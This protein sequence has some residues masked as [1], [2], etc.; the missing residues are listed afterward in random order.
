MGFLDGLLEYFLLIILCILFSYVAIS[1]LERF[2]H[3]YFMH[4]K[5]PKFV[6]RIV[7]DII[8]VF[9][10]HAVRHHGKWYREFDFEPDPEGR[11]DN[12]LIRP[13]DT[14]SG[15]LIAS[16]VILLFFII[17]PLLGGILLLMGL[18]HSRLW[19][20]LHSQMHIPKPV[21]FAQWKIYQYLACYHYMHHQRTNKNFNIVF[22]LADYLLGSLAKPRLRDLRQMLYL[23]YLTPR[24][25][26]VAARVAGKRNIAEKRRTELL[27]LS[28]S[29]SA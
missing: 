21:F 5:L 1:F 9:E 29:I 25:T 20:M 16:P 15:I 27:R 10:S 17:S 4:R 2:V 22:P 13:L 3:K 23:G 26:K 12:I 6:Y 28:D 14:L 19:N 7:P 18:L 11:Y 24:S 8:W